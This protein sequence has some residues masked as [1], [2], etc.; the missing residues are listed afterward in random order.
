MDQ[1]GADGKVTTLVH[2]TYLPTENGDDWRIACMPNMTE[3]GCTQH[4]PNYQRTNDVR[5]TT[6]PWCKEAAIFKQI[7]GRLHAKP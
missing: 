5:A 4:H 2:F 1:I 6:C 3:F 7:Q